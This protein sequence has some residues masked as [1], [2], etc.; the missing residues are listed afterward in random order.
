MQWHLFLP[1][2]RAQVCRRISLVVDVGLE[3][4]AARRAANTTKIGNLIDFPPRNRPPL[5]N[6]PH[7]QTTISSRGVPLYFFMNWQAMICE[8]SRQMIGRFSRSP[9]KRGG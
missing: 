5:L 2:A 6:H 4:L 7:L 9:L 3:K 1:T 8:S